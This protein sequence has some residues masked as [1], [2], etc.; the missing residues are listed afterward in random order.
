MREL[1]V[2]GRT[3]RELGETVSEQDTIL[4]AKTKMNF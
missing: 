3:S 4:F 2:D 1:E